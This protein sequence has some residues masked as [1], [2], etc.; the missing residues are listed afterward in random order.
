MPPPPPPPATGALG[1]GGGADHARLPP[2]RQGLLHHKRRPPPL[3]GHDGGHLPRAGLRPTPH[4]VRSSSSSSRSSSSSSSSRHRL[5]RAARRR[6]IRRRAGPAC[7]ARLRQCRHALHGPLLRPPPHPPCKS[8][9]H[10][11]RRLPFFLIYFIALIVQYL[12]VP[13]LKLFGRDLQVG[14]RVAGW[15]AAPQAGGVSQPVLRTLHPPPLCP[16]PA[17]PPLLPP[18]SPSLPKT[19]QSDFTP[20]RITLAASNRTFSCA[21]ARR[22]F[23]YQPQVGWLHRGGLQQGPALCPV[24]GPSD[25]HGRARTRT[26][27]RWRVRSPGVLCTAQAAARAPAHRPRPCFLPDAAP[28]VHGRGTGA[29]F[30]AL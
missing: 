21:A 2:R 27:Q 19:P 1:G 28:G 15:E 16:D 26:H 17:S 29:H 8:T 14:L 24:E 13:L 20:F 25:T 3:L 9:T 11:P 7:S 30:E 18:S 5:L 4:Q 12:V 22:D 10:R 6:A 23:G